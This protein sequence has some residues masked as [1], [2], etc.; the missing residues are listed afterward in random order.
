MNWVERKTKGRETPTWVHDTLGSTKE[1]GMHTEDAGAVVAG[2]GGGESWCHEK[3][4]QQQQGHHVLVVRATTPNGCLRAALPVDRAARASK[5][6][7]GNSNCSLCCLCTAPPAQAIAPLL[8][9]LL[10][11]RPPSS[12]VVLVLVAANAPLAFC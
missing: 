1:Q 6:A 12:L 4:Q 5:Q 8:P 7:S 9:S 11:T 10:P 3:Q 2:A